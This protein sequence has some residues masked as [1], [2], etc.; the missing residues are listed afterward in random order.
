[1]ETV[2]TTGFTNFSAAIE[3]RPYG[4]TKF[5]GNSIMTSQYLILF[6]QWKYKD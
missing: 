6:W 3:I 4:Y 5:M 1:M 2:E